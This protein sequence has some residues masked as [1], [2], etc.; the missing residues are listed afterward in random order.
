PGRVNPAQAQT[1]Y[2]AKSSVGIPI[3]SPITRTATGSAYPPMRSTGRSGSRSSSSPW[4]ISSMRGPSAATRPGVN[5]LRIIPR[6]RVWSGGSELSRWNMYWS[7][8]LS[9]VTYPARRNWSQAG[10][11]LDGGRGHQ[12]GELRRRHAR[13]VAGRWPHPAEVPLGVADRVT[14][15]FG[16]SGGQP[17]QHR[18]GVLDD[19]VDEVVPL[20]PQRRY[21]HRAEG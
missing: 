21:R 1:W 9:P 4:T 17:P 20:R 8:S 5:A 2:S 18:I 6:S 11:A 10:P 13:R 12:A 19:L 14:V 7:V 3:S 16:Q 15:Q